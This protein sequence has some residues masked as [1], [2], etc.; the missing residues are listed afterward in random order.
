MNIAAD[1]P[2]L[3]TSIGSAVTAAVSSVA[4]SLP[5]LPSGVTNVIPADWMPFVKYA[6]VFAL[7]GFLA[8][9]AIRLAFVLGFP[10]V[11]I[12]AANTWLGRNWPYSLESWAIGVAVCLVLSELLRM[13][14]KG[15]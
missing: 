9:I 13:W 2:A 1:L 14:R 5:A 8:R 11:V 15:H 12:W 7:F 6:L 10:F 4:T 3:L